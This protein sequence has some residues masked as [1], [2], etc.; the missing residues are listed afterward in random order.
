M[1]GTKNRHAY[2]EDM[3]KLSESSARNVGIVFCD[4]NGLKTANDQYGHE[5]GD[6]LINE[7]VVLLTEKF[8]AVGI[9]EHLPFKN[10]R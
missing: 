5:A 7:S 8:N 10:N 9:A 4:I 3:R 1:T 2:F 6:A